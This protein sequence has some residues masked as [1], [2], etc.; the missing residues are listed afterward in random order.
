MRLFHVFEDVILLSA[1]DPAHPAVDG[2]HPRAVDA[3]DSPG[4]RET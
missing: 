2:R 3:L 1:I 4:R